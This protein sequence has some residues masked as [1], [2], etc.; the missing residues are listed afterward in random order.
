LNK[1]YCGNKP[2][3]KTGKRP[4]LG[5][6]LLETIIGVT[7]LSVGILSILSVSTR[8]ISVQDFV[9]NREGAIFL[10]QDGFE[11]IKSRL[12]DNFNKCSVDLGSLV[13]IW[14]CW[15]TITATASECTCDGGPDVFLD[16]EG[17]KVD[18][19][20]ENWSITPVAL[21]SWEPFFYNCPM[22]ESFCFYSHIDLG[23]Y[24][25]ATVYKRKI[26]VE[27]RADYNGDGYDDMVRIS[28][29]VKWPERGDY[30][31][32]TTT[33]EFYNWRWRKSK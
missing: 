27:D 25:E 29:V 28:S 9:K 19:N 33:S 11:I 13:Y 4:S 22:S 8:L 30:K 23:S 7:I 15:G 18:F 14:N 10:S 5:F 31:Y 3:N 20:G 21:N 16:T 2:I 26:S 12:E 24:S 6:G 1:I 32:V 17:Y